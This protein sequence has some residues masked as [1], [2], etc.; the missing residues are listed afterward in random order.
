MVGA[1]IILLIAGYGCQSNVVNIVPEQIRPDAGP[2]HLLEDRDTGSRGYQISDPNLPPQRMKVALLW[3]EDKTEN[4]EMTHWRY[5]LQRLLSSQLKEI[6]MVRLCGGIDYACRKLGI[7][8]GKALDVARARTIGEIIEAQRVIWGSYRSQDNKWRVTAQVLNVATGQVSADLNAA[9]DD[10]LDVGNELNKQILK[11]LNITPSGEESQKIQRRMT[12]S[13][14]ALEWFSQAL[15]LQEENKP[16]TE[17]EDHLRKAIAADSQFAEAHCFLAATL[18]SQGKLIQAEQVIHQTLEIRPDYAKAHLILAHMLLLQEKYV[19]GEIALLKACQLDS[20]D[21][22]SLSLRGQLYTMQE[23]LD[24][25]IALFNQA[26]L[27]D[28]LNAEIHAC[29]GHTYAFKRERKKAIAELKE[30][31]RLNPED[32]N[33]EQMICQAYAML[34]EIPLAV[35]H[36]EK[37]VKLARKTGVNPELV[38][39]LEKR[40]LQLK[41]GLTPNFIQASIPRVYT[42]QMLQATLAEILTKTELELVINP[43]APSPEIKNWARQ[44]T[45][46][47]ESDMD[48]AQALFNGLTRRIQPKGGRG[49]RTA[50]EVFADWNKP[51]ESF[52]CQEYA[53]LFVALARAV[54]VNAFYVHV[55]KDYNGKVVYHDCAVVF[56]GDQALIIDPA[57]HWFGAPHQDFLIL[58]DLQTVAH[59]LFQPAGPDRDLSRCQIA[60]KLHPDFAWGQLALVRALG[61]VGRWREARQAL[62]VALK[63]EPDRWDAYL[64]QGLLAAQDENLNAAEG[65]LRKSLELNPED[66]ACH[67]VLGNILLGQNRLREARAELRACLRYD[68]HPEMAEEARRS[69]VQINEIIG[70]GDDD[71][72][73]FNR[74]SAYSEL[75]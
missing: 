66:A 68:P 72:D 14:V 62:A 69:I 19:E 53:K 73:F 51:E 25:A 10:W 59:Q 54:N 45:Q 3:F 15:A 2:T 36:Y 33:V 20:D 56:V 13:P 50:R 11:E 60:V 64:C 42:D 49:T 7:S 63:L 38:D 26:R 18:G 43:L 52:S 27:L 28:P 48:K 71:E 5:T 70:I 12:A 55:D 37:F 41:A 58:D 17:Q 4:P 34:G 29:L 35:E 16:Y 65:Y 44:L 9:S 74:I 1:V 61:R 32:I 30:A 6:N 40:G 23:K 39:S 22:E 75:V 67:F 46:N 31:E 8:Q 24:E 47:A 21:S 57:Y